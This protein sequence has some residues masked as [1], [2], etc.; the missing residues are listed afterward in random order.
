MSIGI[1]RGD[2]SLSKVMLTNMAKKLNMPL[3][4]QKVD[5]I[6]VLHKNWQ[7]L[8]LSRKLWQPFIFA[9]IK[10]ARHVLGKLFASEN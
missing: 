2:L 5:E 7:E 4:Y 1:L 9:C 3:I 6:Q 8:L 10:V